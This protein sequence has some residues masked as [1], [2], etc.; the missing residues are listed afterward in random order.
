[1]A[2]TQFFITLRVAGTGWAFVRVVE[3]PYNGVTQRWMMQILRSH[4][5]AGTARPRWRVAR[6][7]IVPPNI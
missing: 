3:V 1:M 5:Y 7:V 4:I 2:G 6:F